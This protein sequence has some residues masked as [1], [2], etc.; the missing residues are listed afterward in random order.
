M[1]V[2]SQSGKPGARPTLRRLELPLEV[3]GAATS[4]DS[5]AYRQSS[6]E[7]PR[8]V[9]A[10][11]RAPDETAGLEAVVEQ[12]RR[13]RLQPLLRTFQNLDCLEFDQ[14]GRVVLLSVSRAEILRA[15]RVV[16]IGD[17]SESAALDGGDVAALDMARLLGAAAHKKKQRK[18]MRKYM[19]NFMQIRDFRQIDPAFVAKP[20]LWVRHNV[21]VVSL[22]QV[23]ALI[24]ADRLLLFQPE[25]PAV[26]RSART[27]LERLQAARADADAYAPFEFR[28]LEAI[29]IC[30]CVSLESDLSEFEP[31]LVRALNELSKMTTA[32]QL[33]QLRALKLQLG[34]FL[35]RVQNVQDAL[36]ELLDEDE[37]MSR[38]YLSQLRETGN[39]TRPVGEHEEVEQI[40]EA[41]LQ[42]V[43][44]IRNRADLISAATADT[45]DIVGIQLG[46]M[47]NRLLVLDIAASAALASF[48]LADAVISFFHSNLPLPIYQENNGSVVW[49][50]VVTFAAVG[51]AIAGSTLTLLWMRRIGL[52]Q[53]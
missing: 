32:L 8:D 21:L 19:R 26:Q 40:L 3:D 13:A 44:H 11:T 27:I 48:A 47:R 9:S 46:I 10:D 14:H 31:K 51:F 38:M 22:E 28:A 16:H 43:A 6:T 35:V 2:T 20:A 30:V 15:A 7:K 23:R 52:L 53:L 5:G 18:R 39:Q 45:E 36:R 29:L 1:G 37:D 17:A 50:I 12:A 41:Y 25:Q 49:F 4:S 24:F 34:A 33:E 42:V